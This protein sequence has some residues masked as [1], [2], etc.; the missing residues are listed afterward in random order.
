MSF[1]ITLTT[2]AQ[3][4]AVMKLDK[5]FVGTDS[6]MGVA[7]FWDHELKHVLREAPISKRVKVHAAFLERGVPFDAA[8]RYFITTDAALQIMDEM[9]LYP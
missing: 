2:M 9:G 7:C 4:T 1:T 8:D 6:Y 5:G 3:L